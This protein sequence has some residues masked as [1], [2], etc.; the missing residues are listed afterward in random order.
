[1]RCWCYNLLRLC[2]GLEAQPDLARP[3]L[4]ILEHAALVGEYNGLNL[5]N[6]LRAALARNQVDSTL[7]AVWRAMLDGKPAGFLP[8]RVRDGFDGIARM[9]AAPGHR[10]RVE[11]VIYGLDR[12]IPILEREYGDADNRERDE[13]L[14]DW[15]AQIRAVWGWEMLN[16]ELLSASGSRK[17]PEWV[18]EVLGD[19]GS[20]LLEGEESPEEAARKVLRE[21]VSEVMNDIRETPFGSKRGILGAAQHGLA[22]VEDRY[23]ASNPEA[24]AILGAVREEVWQLLGVIDKT[25]NEVISAINQ[26]P[27]SSKQVTLLLLRDKLAHEDERNRE[28]DPVAAAIFSAFEK[29]V[30]LSIQ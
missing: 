18:I 10:V 13:E 17:W 3:L 19:V 29:Q 12:L 9:P 20:I 23:R 27:D 4:A 8:G 26:S 30:A 5:R 11:D 15:F 22:R 16:Q 6:D 24:A 2:A 28:S 14:S 1:M 25:A 7:A 21:V